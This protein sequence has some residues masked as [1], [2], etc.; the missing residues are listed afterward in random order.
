MT[1]VSYL[2]PERMIC[3][4][5]LR[6]R[7]KR[8]KSFICSDFILEL[9]TKV[10]SHETHLFCGYDGGRGREDIECKKIA[11]WSVNTCEISP[12]CLQ[13]GIKHPPLHLLT[14]RQVKCFIF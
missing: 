6:I 14:L 2:Y 12:L 9:L 3:I 5:E 8:E 11:E 10:F 4:H 7:S 13:S 1:S